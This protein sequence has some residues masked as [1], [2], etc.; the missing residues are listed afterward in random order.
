M[1]V[2]PAPDSAPTALSSARRDRRLRR[3]APAVPREVALR[4][5][6]TGADLE[7]RPEWTDAG[8]WSQASGRRGGRFYG[9]PHRISGEIRPRRLE[10]SK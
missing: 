8:Q 10:S 4:A 9:A 3:R 1:A 7:A 5:V 6:W 2:R